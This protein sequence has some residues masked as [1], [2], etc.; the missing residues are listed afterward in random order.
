MRWFGPAPWAPICD[1]CERAPVPVGMHCARCEE[2]LEDGDEGVL[3]PALG[4][5]HG[6]FAYHADCHLRGIIGGLNHLRGRCTCCGGTEPPDPPGMSK[7]EAAWRAVAYW[8][9]KGRFRS[10]EADEEMPGS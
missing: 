6:E 7:R 8:H 2:A 3:I 4:L 10:D 5:R 1:D 9:F